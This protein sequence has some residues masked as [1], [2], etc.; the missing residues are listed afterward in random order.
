MGQSC[1]E[2][3]GKTHLCDLTPEYSAPQ[4][5]IPAVCFG[6]RHKEVPEYS[7][8]LFPGKLN[9]DSRVAF[10]VKIYVCVVGSIKFCT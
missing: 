5:P 1:V 2:P 9:L 8:S 6:C 3:D 10:D 7:F 4:H